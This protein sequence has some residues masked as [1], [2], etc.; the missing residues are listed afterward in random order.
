MALQYFH[1][2]F[3]VYRIVFP[4]FFIFLAYGAEYQTLNSAGH[5]ARPS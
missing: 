3:S 2:I 4:S 5:E 1:R